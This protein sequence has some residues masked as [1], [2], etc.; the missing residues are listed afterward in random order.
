MRCRPRE[1]S[2]SVRDTKAEMR[3]NRIHKYTTSLEPRTP[4]GAVGK[5]RRSGEVCPPGGRIE[6]CI[7]W[8]S[9][10]ISAGAENQASMSAIALC[11]R[12]AATACSARQARSRSANAAMRKDQCQAVPLPCKNLVRGRDF[13]RAFRL[14]PGLRRECRNCAALVHGLHHPKEDWLKPGLRAPG[15]MILGSRAYYTVEY[16]A[17]QKR[18][19]GS[20]EQ[21]MRKRNYV[22]KQIST[23]CCESPR[24]RGGLRRCESPIATPGR[25]GLQINR[26]AGRSI[27][28]E[29]I[30][31]FLTLIPQVLP[32]KR[33]WDSPVGRILDKVGQNWP[34][35]AKNGQGWPKLDKAGQNWTAGGQVFQPF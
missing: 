12:W 15:R 27:L 7:R 28:P 35:V 25:S 20:G 5:R 29:W 16:T 24:N 34:K 1:H 22:M 6:T 14:K 2:S 13:E 19:A 8:P 3:R 4:V 9:T 32:E 26:C 33:V 23:V 11:T 10:C 31:I 17:K 30:W 18:G 21:D